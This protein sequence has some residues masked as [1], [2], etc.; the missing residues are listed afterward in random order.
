MFAF[1]HAQ[2][3]KTVNAGGGGQKKTKFCPHMQLLN[4]PLNSK[5][6]EFSVLPKHP[7]C[8]KIKSYKINLTFYSTQ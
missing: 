1:V 2:G 4:D 8:P 3:M 6:A 5:I 7:I